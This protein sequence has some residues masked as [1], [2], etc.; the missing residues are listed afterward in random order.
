MMSIKY[1]LTQPQYFEYYTYKHHHHMSVH[2]GLAHNI[3]IV[4][5][6]DIN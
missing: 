3:L 6:F 5:T 4:I 2:D 1:Y